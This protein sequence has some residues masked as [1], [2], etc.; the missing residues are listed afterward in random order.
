M[1]G[2]A[3]RRRVE[4]GVG[5][6]RARRGTARARSS[7][8]R[9]RS[10]VRSGGRRTA[11]GRFAGMRRGTYSIVARDPATGELGRRRAVALVRASG[12]SCRGR[13]PGVGAVAT[14]SIAE[15]AYG[16]RLLD[17]LA[18]GEPPHDALAAELAADPQAP[19]PPGRRRRRARAAPPC[20]T[21]ER[22]IAFAG[23]RARRGLQRAGEHDGRARGLAGDGARR[24]TARA[25]PLARRLLAAL[26]AAEAHGGDVRGRQ[27]AALLVVP[28]RGRGVADDASTC[29]SRTT[30]SRS[31]SSTGC[32]TCTTPTSSRR[33]GDDLAGEG[34]H[35]EA[36]ER[37]RARQRAGARTTTSCCSGPGL[38]A[39]QAGDMP[40]ALE[41]V[42][43]GDRAAARLAR[44]ARAPASRT[45]PRARPRC[46]R[47][48]T[49][50]ERERRARQYEGWLHVQSSVLL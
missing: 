13:A 47:R 46:W 6:R 10:V 40:L 39:A 20:H 28:A 16:P 45:S 24:S 12:R 18:A 42:R 31:P 27:S 7:T 19:L 8:A 49:R 41:R 34:R 38:A 3:R 35:D 32:S 5:A 9:A 29:A 1:P 14:Q 2:E 11:T 26:H 44:P 4:V 36:G 33:S 21:G 25:G 17:R 15:P 43:R 48:W 37:L 30:P 50:A 22:C 23:R